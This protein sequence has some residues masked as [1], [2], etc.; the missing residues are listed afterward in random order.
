MFGDDWASL[1]HHWAFL[2]VIGL[3]WDSSMPLVALGGGRRS[4]WLTR[5]Y[6][7]PQMRALNYPSNRLAIYQF[8]SVDMDR[9]NGV[10]SVEKC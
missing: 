8:R 5:K 6:N 9:M 4:I 7:Y 3:S 1:E 2:G 10:V